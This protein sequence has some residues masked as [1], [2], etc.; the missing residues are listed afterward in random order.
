MSQRELA[1]RSCSPLS[2]SFCLTD[3]FLSN[4]GRFRKTWLAISSFLIQCSLV[5]K[6]N[7]FLDTYEGS[8][9]ELYDKKLR[10]FLQKTTRCDYLFTYGIFE[11]YKFARRFWGIKWQGDTHQ[12]GDFAQ[13]NGECLTK[14]CDLVWYLWVLTLLINFVRLSQEFPVHQKNATSRTKR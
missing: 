14:A 2:S 9:V 6:S 4:W 13:T 10:S 7:R 11:L 12:R 3:R 8:P 5:T 1:S